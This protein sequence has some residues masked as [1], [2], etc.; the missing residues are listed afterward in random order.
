MDKLIITILGIALSAV[1]ILWTSDYMTALY[2]NAQ[3]V[4]KAQKWLADA[5][6]VTLAARQAG[7]LSLT[8][9]N[10]E[11]GSSTSAVATA[12]VPTYLRDLPQHNGLYVFAPCYITGGAT[13]CPRYT[14]DSTHTSDA[15]IIAATVENAAVCAEI[16]KIA[17]RGSATL[18]TATVSGANPIVITTTIPAKT[19][20]V[21]TTP[22]FT[23][24]NASGTY[25]F[26]YRVFL[27]R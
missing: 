4:A 24:L 11:Q 6:Q 12:I 26:L 5:G 16:Q 19:L 7:S 13:S 25:Y 27:D 22:Q 20:L 23:C 8:G 21:N 15:T 17:N 18:P 14:T 10:W 9:D 2:T 3:S 1:A